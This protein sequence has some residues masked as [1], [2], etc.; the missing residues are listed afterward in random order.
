MLPKLGRQL[1][2]G[3]SREDADRLLAAARRASHR[4]AFEGVRNHAMIATFIFTGLRKGELLNLRMEDVNLARMTVYVIKGKGNK[5]RM[6]PISTRLAAILAEYMA[7]RERLGR[8]SDYFFLSSRDDRP[9]TPQILKRVV[10]DLQKRSKV[11]FGIHA[12]RHTF[13][14]LMLEGGCDIYSLSQMMGHTKITTTTIY[15]ACSTRMMASSIERHPL[16]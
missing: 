14:T 5:D 3:L 13:A 2:K 9:A 16:N 12:L 6:V 4:Y 1:P 10:R 11:Q 7:E 8:N 15:L